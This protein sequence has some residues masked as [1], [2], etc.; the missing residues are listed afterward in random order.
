MTARD[1][2]SATRSRR[3]LG[4]DLSDPAGRHPPGGRGGARRR[5]RR[6]HGRPR[7]AAPARAAAL[8]RV[9]QAEPSRRSMPSP[10]SSRRTTSS[11]P[12]WRRSSTRTR[13]G[14]PA[15]CG[16]PGPT[17]GRTSSAALE[18][19]RRPG[20]PTSAEQRERAGRHPPARGRRRSAL[21]RPRTA[22]AHR[23]PR[24]TCSGPAWRAEQAARRPC[25]GPGGRARGAGDAARVER[26]GGGPQPEGRRGPRWSTGPP[27]S[28][29][30]GLASGRS[31]PSSRARG[32]PA[33]RR[34]TPAPAPERAGAD[35]PSA[36]ESPPAASGA[37]SGLR[38]RRRA[39]R[40]RHRGGARRRRGRGHWP[41]PWRGGRGAGAGPRGRSGRARPGRRTARAAPAHRLRRQGPAA[42]VDGPARRRPGAA[43]PARWRVRRLGRGGRAPAAH[44]RGGAHR[45]RLQRHDDGLAR[46]GGRR[47][48][49]PAG[50][51]GCPTWPPA[52]PPAVELVFDGAEVEPL[53]GAG[54]RCGRWCG[55][56][57]PTP[58]VE[59]DDVVID[60]VGRIPAATPVIVA[61]SDN[62]VRDGC[63]RRGA[64]VLHARQLVTL[65]RR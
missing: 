38:C 20:R 57:S 51:G 61:S 64:N 31:R 3:R 21:A 33:E 36:P 18:A 42:G 23:V 41:T 39:R 32:A 37:A 8:P 44:A 5:P 65:L 48:A 35:R 53:T 19:D 7:G 30:P 58:G 34:A 9:R 2:R 27:S 10:A 24:S 29:R 12:G 13:S 17:G 45:R 46:A 16:W 47:A 4:G 49:P 56:G 60:L 22:T 54:R 55:C 11:E 50:G 15:G 25:R 62:R 40:R 43:G 14:G 63:R 28:T 59:A 6:P 26:R 52:R 1:A